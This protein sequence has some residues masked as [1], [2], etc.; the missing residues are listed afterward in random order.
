MKFYSLI[1]ASFD[2]FLTPLSLVLARI[3]IRGRGFSS[4][5]F[6]YSFILVQTDGFSFYSVCYNPLLSLSILMLKLSRIDSVESFPADSYPKY[7]FANKFSF[8]KTQN[9]STFH[10]TFKET[11]YSIIFTFIAESYCNIKLKTFQN[12]IP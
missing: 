8:K 1:L 10:S 9:Y 12:N 4:D 6:I 11:K 5:L 2:D 7:F 3:L